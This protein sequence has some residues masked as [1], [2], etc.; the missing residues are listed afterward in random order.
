MNL[1]KNGFPD[2]AI[3]TRQIETDGL[4]IDIQA[5]EYSEHHHEVWIKIGVQEFR[6]GDPL[7][8]PEEAA[9]YVDMVAKAFLKTR[10]K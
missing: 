9:W 1:D 2:T 10:P 8:T 7:D 3:S 6:V 5:R 4:P